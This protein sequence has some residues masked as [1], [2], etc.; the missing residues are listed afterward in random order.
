MNWTPSGSRPTS[1]PVIAAVARNIVLNWTPGGP[2]L[3]AVD[4]AHCISEWGHDFRPDYREIAN[5][6][7]QLGTLVCVL[8]SAGFAALRIRSAPPPQERRD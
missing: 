2:R 4:E 7:E 1:D 3:I 8:G 6:R 5:V